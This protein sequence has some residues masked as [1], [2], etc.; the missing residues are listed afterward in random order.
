V[1]FFFIFSLFMLYHSYKFMSFKFSN[2]SIFSP[3]FLTSFFYIISVITSF[4]FEIGLFKDFINNVLVITFI[5]SLLL[6]HVNCK[7][8]F[9][10]SLKKLQ[11]FALIFIS[12]IAFLGICK[13]LF[14]FNGIK[15]QFLEVTGL[16]YP[17]GTSLSIDHN[18]FS[19]ACIIA[20]VFSIP[21][22]FKKLKIAYRIL[23][24][25]AIFCLSISVFLSTSR[26][27]IIIASSLELI[28][29]LFWFFS[30]LFKKLHFKYFRQNTIG[31]VIVNILS[32]FIL[33]FIFIIHNSFERKRWLAN[34]SFNKNEV[35]LFLN[36]LIEAGGTILKGNTDVSKV[37]SLIWES[38]FDS[39]YPYSGWAKGNYS[40]IN[41]IEGENFTIV[42]D[43][44][45]SMKIDSSSFLKSDSTLYFVSQFSHFYPIKDKRNIVSVYIYVSDDFNGDEVYLNSGDNSFGFTKSDYNLSA[46]GEWQKQYISFSVF[47]NKSWVEFGV[48]KKL[49]NI[50]DKLQG[51]VLFA[52][53][54]IKLIDYSSDIPISW[55]GTNCTDTCIVFGDGSKKNHLTSIGCKIDKESQF[56]LWGSLVYS[57]MVLRKFR[58]EIDKPYKSSILV[59]VSKDFNGKN[60]KLEIKGNVNGE[61]ESSYDLNNKG[62]W[63]ELVINNFCEKNEECYVMTYFDLPDYKNLSKLIG[64]VI[65]AQPKFEAPIFDPK[66]PKTYVSIKFKEDFPV[67]GYNSVIVPEGTIGCRFDKNA[68]GKIWSNFFYLINEFNY[69]RVESGDSVLSSINCYVSENFNGNTV[70][71]ELKGIDNSNLINHYNLKNK[72]K[73]VKLSLKGLVKSDG[74]VSG[75]FFVSQNGVKDFS[76]LKGY[77]TFAYPELKVIK[78]KNKII[79]YNKV[80]KSSIPKIDKVTLFNKNIFNKYLYF[81]PD[82]SNKSSV[83]SAPVFE[84]EVIDD[85]FAGPRLEYWRYA[86]YLYNYEY[87][88]W[89]RIFGG[90]TEYTRKFAEKFRNSW[91]K[92]EFD[93]PHNP[94]LS[95]LLYSGILGLLTYIWFLY[96]AIYYY[97]LYRKEYCSL[98]VSFSIAFIYAFFSAN[99]PFDPAILG[100]L[101]IIPYFI[102]FFHLST[103]ND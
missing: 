12:F 16:G 79:G 40:L 55:A 38:N 74:I 14:L 46:K 100:V 93:Y 103:Y 1:F 88:W 11:I 75:L 31:L 26:R 35:S 8:L 73:W 19:L 92:T 96:K 52:Y 41:K 54:E 15:F 29:F 72:G 34:S 42:P 6:L 13:L 60:V 80:N 33:I 94:F 28:F 84:R 97:W 3:F 63:Q 36:N 71:L 66:V 101:T 27:G 23:L 82:S 25:F 45:V 51:Y 32:V 24:Q 49:K 48:L 37:D 68:E 44:A 58:T 47:N 61:R 20:I 76:N 10:D 102:H 17:Q 50:K 53:P 89:K 59:F 43:S 77:V 64:Y 9:Y 39:R 65:F 62:T 4:N 87:S 86:I 21:N 69:V 81:Y 2:F 85:H 78:P 30:F 70:S 18:F 22:L 57:P 67:V 98:G 90:G 99:S 56:R 5:F 7:I 83:Q 95:V 91:E